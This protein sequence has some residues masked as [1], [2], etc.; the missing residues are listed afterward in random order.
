MWRG[1]AKMAVGDYAEAQARFRQSIEANRNYPL[2]HFLLAA[3]LA[4]LGCADEAAEE[5]KAGL[6][7][8]PSFTLRRFRLG[9]MSGN[10]NY[11]VERERLIG[12]MRLAGVP[13][14]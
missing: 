13:E 8:A 2:A 10:P 12:A 6:A 5:V 1:A 9:V 14:G 7:I 4:L 11:L 3:A